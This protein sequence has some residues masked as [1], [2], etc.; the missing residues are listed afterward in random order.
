MIGFQFQFKEGEA[1]VV[2]SE[3]SLRPPW[4]L[5]GQPWAWNH[6]SRAGK[7]LSRMISKVVSARFNTICLPVESSFSSYGS[8]QVGLQIYRHA[9]IFPSSTKVRLQKANAKCVHVLTCWLVDV[10]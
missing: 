5:D 7:P 1:P 10:G 4:T 6:T 9:T 2:T 8:R 3:Q